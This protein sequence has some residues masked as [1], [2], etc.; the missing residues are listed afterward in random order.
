LLRVRIGDL[1]LGSLAAGTWRELSA[2]ERRRVL[3][4]PSSLQR[5]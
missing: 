5:R 1:E 2:E 4:M 3:S